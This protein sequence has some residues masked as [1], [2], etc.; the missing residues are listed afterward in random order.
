MAALREQNYYTS[1]S[2]TRFCVIDAI[3]WSNITVLGQTLKGF[4]LNELVKLFGYLIIK[5][6]LQEYRL[7]FLKRAQKWLQWASSPFFYSVIQNPGLYYYMETDTCRASTTR[8]RYFKK[9]FLHTIYEIKTFGA[10][11][12]YGF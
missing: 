3:A 6:S 5:A 2:R 8:S 7:S 11:M 1:A 12:D 9:I 10:G 4:F